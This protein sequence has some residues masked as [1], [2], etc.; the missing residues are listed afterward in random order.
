M[1]AVATQ[2]K[3]LLVDGNNVGR[4]WKLTAILWR[5]DTFAAQRKL[6]E[7]VRV[8]HDAMGWRVSL[9][10]DG[11]GAELTVEQPTQEASFV[12]AHAPTGVTADDV[13][14][15]WVV[16]SRVAE[17][18]VVATADR[19]LRQLVEAQGAS[20]IGPMELKAWLAR[21]DDVARRGAARWNAR[22]I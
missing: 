21:A 18:C 16:N 9:V 2:T 4:A 8:W 11:R 12:V 1:N 6:E 20:V 3:H 22:N 10:F 13:L 7:M 5:R 14:V 17:D 15:Q 19:G